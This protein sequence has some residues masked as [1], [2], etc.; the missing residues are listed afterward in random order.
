MNGKSKYTPVHRAHCS[1]ADS[2]ANIIPQCCPH[3][4]GYPANLYKAFTRD[5]IEF[6]GDSTRCS[7]LFW[8]MPEVLEKSILKYIES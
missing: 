5:D 7:N 2:A 3:I 8:S 1:V 4:F 6:H